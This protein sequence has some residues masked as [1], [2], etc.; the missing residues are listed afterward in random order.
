MIVLAGASALGPVAG[1]ALAADHPVITEV[2]YAVPPG[3]KG[4]ANADGT[5]DAVGDEFIELV[6]PHAHAINLKGYTLVDAEAYN[7]GAARPDPARPGSDKPTENPPATDKPERGKPSKPKTKRAELRFTFPDLELRPGEVVV[8]F[9][10]F[11]QKMTGPVGDA[12]HAP[13]TRH[14]R[15]HNAWVFSMNNE[16]PYCALGNEADMVVLLGPDGKPVECVTWGDVGK[17]SPA[18]VKSEEAPMSAGSVQRE[19]INGKF[20]PHKDLKGD[21][22]GTLFS[23]GVF[24]LNG[25]SGDPA[26][27]PGDAGAGQSSNGKPDAG[28]AGQ[29]ASPGKP[30]GSGRPKPGSGKRR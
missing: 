17:N 15:F 24:S 6:N 29:G 20:V 14:E 18:G 13:P 22:A 12:Q 19:G 2:L 10:G 25:S 7:P 3:P 11:H 9:N 16:G 23:P 4:D 30:G 8:V 5:R 26:P 28:G 27:R 1:G 21:L